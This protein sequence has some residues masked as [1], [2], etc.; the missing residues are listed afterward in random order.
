M[1]VIMQQQAGPGPT[2][3]V[4][5]RIEGAGFGAHVFKGA[6]RDVIAVLGAG[7]PSSLRDAVLA[8]FIPRLGHAGKRRL[9]A[10]ANA[11]R[12]G[13]RAEG[14]PGRKPF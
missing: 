9:R 1:I 2:D 8:E 11:L 7:E 5:R 14:C 6:E 4:V 12:D 10:R 13:D 3:A